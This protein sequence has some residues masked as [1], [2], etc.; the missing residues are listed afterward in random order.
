MKYVPKELK[1]TADISCGQHGFKSLAK[2]VAFVVGFF[3]AL[4]LLLEVL[5]L[6]MAYWIPDSVESKFQLS[7][8]MYE[9]P[10]SREDRLLTSTASGVLQSLLDDFDH[11]ELP[12]DIYL[13]DMGQSNAL[14][15]P[16][17]SIVLS[18]ELL[19]SV[20]TEAG[21]AFVLAHE[22]AHHE[23]RH[24]VR[25]L[26]KDFLLSLLQVFFSSEVDISP[27][28]NLMELHSSRVEEENADKLAAK[29]VLSLY[30]ND[31]NA[32]EFFQI[33]QKEQGDSAKFAQYFSTHP[34][35]PERMKKL[36]TALQ[37]PGNR[38]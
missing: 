2:N 17:G 35:T 11:R 34:W 24:P 31:P 20:Q 9:K 5:V 30:G 28:L 16:G 1:E 6:A 23:L 33:V 10:D 3:L 25:K 26:G 7:G 12:Y 15:L 22:I 36:K 8:Q 21:I 27:G 37:A 38:N 13:A 32:L 29:M 19:K 14:A 4:F 18:R